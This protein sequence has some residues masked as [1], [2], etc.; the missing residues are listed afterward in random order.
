MI[1]P[2]ARSQLL[3]NSGTFLIRKT[4][5]TE[6][7]ARESAIRLGSISFEQKS[8]IRNSGKCVGASDAISISIRS[9][10]RRSREQ[11]RARPRY[12][13]P[14]RYQITPRLDSCQTFPTILTPRFP[15]TS[16]TDPLL[17]SFLVIITLLG[18]WPLTGTNKYAL[19]LTP[20]VPEGK[21]LN[22][23]LTQD[24]CCLCILMVGTPLPL[25]SGRG[26]CAITDYHYFPRLADNQD[27][28]GG[29]VN[30][31]RGGGANYDSENSLGVCVCAL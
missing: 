27:N 30:D 31:Y 9:A 14:P 18:N 29:K 8:M 13:I 7:W 24:W 11:R 28:E 2:H 21:A 1:D 17:T 23:D 6:A 4:G 3:T 10:N 19:V 26:A 5:V 15:R 16:D 20:L 25:T 12:K 22:E